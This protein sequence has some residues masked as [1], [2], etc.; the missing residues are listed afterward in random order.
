MSKYYNDM[1]NSFNSSMFNN[2]FTG[3]VTGIVLLLVTNLK[4][5]QLVRLH[6]LNEQLNIIHKSILDY[7]SHIRKLELKQVL[8]ENDYDDIYDAICM[9]NDI[10]IDI[11]YNMNKISLGINLNKIFI[12]AFNFD[13]HK[14]EIK[15]GEIREDIIYNSGDVDEYEKLIQILRNYRN[16]LFELNSKILNKI[17]ENDIK[18]DLINKSII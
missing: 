8:S 18:I 11:I 6:F 1:G 14:Q 3:I 12:K 10:N 9:A 7:N 5:V 2:I 16:E 17:K 13:A 4:N 15:C